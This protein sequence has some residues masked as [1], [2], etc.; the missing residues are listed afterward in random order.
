MFEPISITTSDRPRH[1]VQ[2]SFVPQSCPRRQWA[3]SAHYRNDRPVDV[4]FIVRRHGTFDDAWG[5]AES[6]AVS[7]RH[8]VACWRLL[9]LSPPELAP[10]KLA[11][12][13]LVVWQTLLLYAP[14]EPEV[15]RHLH[16]RPSGG[17]S[18]CY[19]TPSTARS[20]AGLNRARK[21]VRTTRRASIWHPCARPRAL[22]RQAPQNVGLRRNSHSASQTGRA[23]ALPL[24]RL[25]T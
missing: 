20:W 6:C 16:C 8:G 3:R 24:L 23:A 9:D 11:P 21:T 19:A 12:P 17:L 13:E 2:A 15:C 5:L 14:P 22:V 18:D 25:A 1:S 10:P 4:P 7:T